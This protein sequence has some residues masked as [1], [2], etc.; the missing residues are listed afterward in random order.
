MKQPQ[1]LRGE[2][3]MK[4]GMITCPNCGHEFELSDALTG[5][6]REHLRAELLQE[7]SRREA[8]LNEKLAALKVQQEQ[9]ARSRAQ[10]EEQIEA[11]LKE[12]LAEAESKAAEKLEQRYARQ[13]KELQGMIA[14]TD[15][16]I[17]SFRRQELALRKKQ[18]Q[19]ETAAESLELELARRLGPAR[20]V[21]T[22]SPD[23]GLK[24]LGTPPYDE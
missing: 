18:R 13:L 21:L 4:Q 20:R 15:A 22:V 11:R 8:R 12:R 9:V 17:Q 24:Y 5:R 10:M 3:T 1:H 2:L 7:V 23:S 6:I 14:E 19:L 16:D